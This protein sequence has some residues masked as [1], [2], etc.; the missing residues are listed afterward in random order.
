MAK[1]TKDEEARLQELEKKYANMLSPD[2]EAR[3]AE[4]ES[5][6]GATTASAASESNL[7][8]DGFAKGAFAPEKRGKIAP[9]KDPLMQAGAGLMGMANTIGASKIGQ[10]LVEDDFYVRSLINPA[11][12]SP[13]VSKFITDKFGNKI[14]EQTQAAKEEYPVGYDYGVNLGRSLPALAV[15]TAGTAIIPGL[16]VST[17]LAIGMQ[18]GVQAGGRAVQE[19][20]DVTSDSSLSEKSKRAALGAGA[21]AALTIAGGTLLDGVVPAVGKKLMQSKP[22]KGLTDKMVSGL[23]SGLKRLGFDASEIRQASNALKRGG[24]EVSDSNPLVQLKHLYDEGVLK[25]KKS[26][27]DAANAID[28]VIRVNGKEVEKILTSSGSSVV[29]GTQTPLSKL[30]WDRDIV[31]MTPLK[32]K[33]SIQNT[34]GKLGLDIVDEAGNVRLL[35]LQEAQSAKNILDAYSNFDMNDPLAKLND[36]VV[37]TLGS[38]LRGAIEKASPVIGKLNKTSHAALN[39]RDKL[40]HLENKGVDVAKNR[41]QQLLSKVASSPLLSMGIGAG[42][43]GLFGAVGAATAF[44]FGVSASTLFLVPAG[45]TA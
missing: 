37:K 21:D 2:E 8:P 15:P 20:T 18:G 27:V 19:L 16:A 41:G 30:D 36:H 13:V 5:K 32:L 25:G 1:L 26:T 44:G 45:I 17:P 28:D 39:F 12:S 29:K 31:G 3:L 22:V 9:S 10:S 34:L 24:D 11:L 7:A 33:E 42:A 40:V 4:L 43:G 38:H 14:Q 35:T 6:Y 23:Q